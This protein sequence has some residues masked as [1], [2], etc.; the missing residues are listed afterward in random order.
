M[1]AEPVKNV[2]Y[3]ASMEPHLFALLFG[4]F[5]EPVSSV[6]TMWMPMLISNSLFISSCRVIAQPLLERA[7]KSATLQSDQAGA[8]AQV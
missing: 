4:F 5:T 2:V 6:S 7:D 8:A 3:E 1:A